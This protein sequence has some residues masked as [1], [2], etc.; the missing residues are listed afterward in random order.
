M[1][2]PRRTHAGYMLISFWF[3]TI[4]MQGKALLN[5]ATLLQLHMYGSPSTSMW[6]GVAAHLALHLV[7]HVCSQAFRLNIVIRRSQIICIWLKQPVIL[8]T[9]LFID[10]H[11]NTATRHY[12]LLPFKTHSRMPHK[13]RQPTDNTNMCQLYWP[14]CLSVF[15]VTVH[16]LHHPCA[17]PPPPPHHHHHHHQWNHHHHIVKVCYNI[18]PLLQVPS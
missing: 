1:V 9:P 14:V 16:F 8:T 3:C 2:V 11:C 18:P 10:V 5:W 6:G 7:Q 4:N 13:T 12:L 15:W 17:P